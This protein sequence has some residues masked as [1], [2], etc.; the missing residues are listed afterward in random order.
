MA[1]QRRPPASP[2]TSPY[3]VPEGSQ[4]VPGFIGRRT[5]HQ[6]R[7]TVATG[8]SKDTGCLRSNPSS[9]PCGLLGRGV[10][11]GQGVR[12][13]EEGA[14]GKNDEEVTGAAGA[15]R[16]LLRAPSLTFGHMAARD[17]PRLRELHEAWFPVR[18]DAKFYG[19][20]CTDPA[21]WTWGAYSGTS[22]TDVAVGSGVG[23]GL[24]C[25]E[26]GEGA[27]RGERGVLMGA[28]VS[29]L[30]GTDVCED[31]DLVELLGDGGSGGGGGGGGGNDGEQGGWG[32]NGYDWHSSY[33]GHSSYGGYEG[34]DEREGW[35]GV[36]TGQQPQ[37]EQQSWQQQQQQ[38]QQ[39][40]PSPLPP[41]PPP[42]TPAVIPTV[43]YIMT[44]GSDRRFRRRGLGRLLLRQCVEKAASIPSCKA[45]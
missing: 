12:Q 38:Q 2:V 39:Q 45:V 10:V 3:P 26:S 35:C 41:P 11:E 36:G 28:V 15:A 20:V 6:K 25:G 32:C 16:A 14:T 23:C 18:Y 9:P 8:T 27:A 13:H 21:I 33:D 22:H 44:L 34:H 40:S 1:E 19:S 5:L 31:Q 43:M 30:V 24:G 37:Y 29:Q 7:G 42:P 4:L 17:I